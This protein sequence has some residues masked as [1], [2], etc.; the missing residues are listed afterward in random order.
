VL[1]ALGHHIA[2]PWYAQYRSPMKKADEVARFCGDASEVVVCH[3]RPCD[4]V[5]FYLGRDDLKEFR[6]KEMHLL[7]PSLLQRRRTVILFT[8]RHS[9]KGFKEA[10]PPNLRVVEECHCGLGALP[11]LPESWTRH[12]TDG[13]GETA[14][15]L[16]DIA[17]VERQD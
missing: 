5:A 2:L 16:C 15:G 7:I 17:V 10:L 3:P 8:H 13:M 12:A 1:L 11:G 14:L 6:S 9:L 4:S